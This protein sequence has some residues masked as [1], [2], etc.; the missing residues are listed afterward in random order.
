MASLISTLFMFSVLFPAKLWFAPDQPLMVTIRPGEAVHLVMTDF[1]GHVIPPQQEADYDKETQVDVK[2]TFNVTSGTYILYAVPKG[3]NLPDFVGTP[4]VIEQ[5][6]DRRGAA[7]L[8]PLVTKVEPLRYAVMETDHGSMTMAFYYDVAPNTVS[9]FLSLCEEGY[10]DGI[11]FHRIISNFV[12][13]AGD[14]LSHT[15]R[16]GTGGPGYTINPEFNNKPHLKGVLSM[17]RQGDPGEQ[18]GNPPGFQAANSA[19]SQFFI[20]LDYSHTK[21]L[22]GKYTV[23]GRVVDGMDTM[24]QLAAVPTGPGDRP[25]EEPLIKHVTVKTVTPGDNPYTKLK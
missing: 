4:L 8:A 10:Y 24:D 17:A 9:N 18:Q 7:G 2:K 3:K 23:F 15:E 19:S 1:A 11:G 22:D 6:V 16:A 21:A 12:L 20:C 13:Q 14:P 5:R 25:L